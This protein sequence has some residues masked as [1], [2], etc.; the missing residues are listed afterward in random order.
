MEK[1]NARAAVEAGGRCIRWRGEASPNM[2]IL[3]Q[4]ERPPGLPRQAAAS[5]SQ[6][7]ARIE[8]RLASLERMLHE[9]CGVLLNAKFPYGRGTDR[10]ARRG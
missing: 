9:F 8:A 5:E 7:L 3:A 10:W 4:T 2:R 1:A 6:Q